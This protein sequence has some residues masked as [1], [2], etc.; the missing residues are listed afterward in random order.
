[1]A[2]PNLIKSRPNGSKREPC[3]TRVRPL[4]ARGTQ[5]AMWSS[6]ATLL[7]AAAAH[8]CGNGNAPL[9]PA[10]R[11]RSPD[12]TGTATQA[13]DAAP[14]VRIPATNAGSSASSIV[15][16]EDSSFPSRSTSV[17]ASPVTDDRS[18]NSWCGECSDDETPPRRQQPIPR[19][20]TST[21]T[22]DP[23]PKHHRARSRTTSAAFSNNDA[24]SISSK[25]ASSS[26]TAAKME[27]AEFVKQS[28]EHQVLSDIVCGSHKC[29]TSLKTVKRRCNAIMNYGRVRPTRPW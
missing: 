8:S 14:A 24:Q 13:R 5:P 19:T 11:R 28:Q 23:T 7:A 27:Q 4:P 25:S 16:K 1:M 17:G 18:D 26:S 3:C 29:E 2:I 10:K 12:S 15:T 22:N 9:P 21:P 20:R 6:V